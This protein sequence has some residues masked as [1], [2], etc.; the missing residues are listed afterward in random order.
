M[1][2]FVSEG[3]FIFPISSKVIANEYQG[4]PEIEIKKT[5]F[6]KGGKEEILQVFINNPTKSIATIK[7]LVSEEG[8]C[9]LVENGVKYP[10]VLTDEG[11]RFGSKKELDEAIISAFS[12]SEE[13]KGT[14]QKPVA[15]AT[16]KNEITTAIIN[17]D[18]EQVISV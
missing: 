11:G 5:K 1:P 14:P 4:R 16:D 2:S 17:L 15:H 7:R 3:V 8:W 13:E 6:I 12:S 10:D 9:Q 18:I